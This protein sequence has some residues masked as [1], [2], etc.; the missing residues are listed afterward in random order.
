MKTVAVKSE[1]D[2]VPNTSTASMT[3]DTSF[4]ASSSAADQSVVV[5]NGIDPQ[6]YISGGDCGVLRNHASKS[7]SC[8]RVAARKC[9]PSKVCV[10]AEPP[11]VLQQQLVRVGCVTDSQSQEGQSS[12]HLP[13]S[14]RSSGCY[15][16]PAS[17]ENASYCPRALL[18]QEDDCIVPEEDFNAEWSYKPEQRQYPWRPCPNIVPPQPYHQQSSWRRVPRPSSVSPPSYEDLPQRPRQQLPQRQRIFP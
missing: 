10:K 18:Y 1:H 11:P 13:S 2:S 12:T 15:D 6:A 14:G 8:P 4:E 9:R 17:D 3:G 7:S 16:G 5:V